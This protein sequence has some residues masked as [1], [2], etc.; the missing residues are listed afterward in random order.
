MAKQY[1]L[2][3]GTGSASINTGLTPTFTIFSLSGL[4]AIAAPGITETP[5]GSGLYRFIY[6]P[7]TVPVVFEAD[8]G[9]ALAT[10]DRYI[11]GSLDPIQ[12]VNEAVTDFSNSFGSTL[13][14]PTTILG[15]LKRVQEYLEGFQ[16]FNKATGAWDIY[17]RGASTLLIEKTLTNTVSTAT[18]S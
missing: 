18:R 14:D 1:W 6:S 4:T 7:T 9:A 10:G 11:D 12:S 17:S 16:S 8:G 15:Y 13:L 3:F 5:T 2:K